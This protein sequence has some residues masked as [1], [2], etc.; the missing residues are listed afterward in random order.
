MASQSVPLTALRYQPELMGMRAITATIVVLG[1]WLL[2]SF[3]IDE[4]GL[5][6]LYAVSGYL[7]SGIIWKNNLY[8]GASGSWVRQLGKFYARRAL[9]IMPPYY[10]S[11]ALGFLLPL[12]TLYQHPGW[13]LLLSSNILCYRLQRWPEGVGHYWSVG[14]EE[15]FYLLWPLVLTLIRGRAIFLWLIALSAVVYRAYSVFYLTATAP[16]YATVLLP[17]CLDLFAAGTLLRLHIIRVGQ[18]AKPWPGWPALVAWGIWWIA[19]G[20]T[21]LTTLPEQLWFILYPSLGA[22]ASY[23]TLRWLLQSPPQARWLNHPAVQWLGTRSY[24]V[25]L[26]H[27]MLPV[28]YQRLVYHVLP[29]SSPWRQWWLEPIPTVLVLTPL[30]LAMCAISWRWLEVPLATLKTRFA[31][32][33][34]PSPPAGRAKSI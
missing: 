27:L 16:V 14:L 33:N 7:I 22:V 18:P 17:G 4:V 11:L 2:V 20:F 15:Q 10:A 31:Y 3:P 19:W 32:N 8:W 23:Q 28:F 12:A 1:H 25:Y 13:F 24:G 30:V 29:A 34:S 21:R 26:Y 6:P 5:L 9:R